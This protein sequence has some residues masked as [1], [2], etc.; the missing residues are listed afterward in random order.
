MRKE[1]HNQQIRLKEALWPFKLLEYQRAALNVMTDSHHQP[2]KA[3]P[4]GP[5]KQKQWVHSLSMTLSGAMI[6][7][8][9]GG[10]WG[11][12]IGA[13]IGLALSFFM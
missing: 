5:K 4:A 1:E 2:S 8:Q 13:V 12:L 10:P 9:I 3:G 6:G 11:A 7:A